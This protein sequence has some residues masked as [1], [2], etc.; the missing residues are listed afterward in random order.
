MGHGPEA[1][2]AVTEAG[3]AFFSCH[4]NDPAEI[5]RHI[6][7]EVKKT[8][9]LVGSVAVFDFDSK[10]WKMCGV[11][12]ISTKIISPANAKNMMAY[13]GIIGLNVPRTLNSQEVNYE[14]G[15]HIIMC[16]DGIKSKWDTVKFGAIQRYDASILSATL[17][18]DFARY[19]DDMSVAVCRVNL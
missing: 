7:N 18:K 4:E 12:N 10:K 16:S 13:N 3:K 2:N 11:G 14:K 6:N 1:A 15:Q 8:R 17:I 19:T 5:I 9:G